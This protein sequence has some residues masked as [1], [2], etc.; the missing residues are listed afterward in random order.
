ML[1]P[2]L[3]HFCSISRARSTFSCRAIRNLSKTLRSC[4]C[5]QPLP[6]KPSASC[7]RRRSL[8]A[9]SSCFPGSG[10][11]TWITPLRSSL[12]GAKVVLY[13]LDLGCPYLYSA[14][15]FAAERRRL[16]SLLT[17][18]QGANRPLN[19]QQDTDAS[20]ELPGLLGLSVEPVAVETVSEEM[21]L[22]TSSPL[23]HVGA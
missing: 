7:R 16:G 4:G 5:T 12:M 11:A 13:N 3:Q 15:Q 6:G 18:M 2:P 1:L 22:V 9:T 17:P 20:Q 23:R 10:T 19:G 21:D 8:Q 14:F